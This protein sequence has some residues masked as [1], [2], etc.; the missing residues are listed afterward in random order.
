MDFRAEAKR[1]FFFLRG[2]LRGAT[3]RGVLWTPA[4][5]RLQLSSLRVET[6][7]GNQEFRPHRLAWQQPDQFSVSGLDRAGHISRVLLRFKTHDDAKR[8]AAVLLEL[9]GV[10]EEPL[11]LQAFEIPARMKSRFSVISL[12]WILMIVVLALVTFPRTLVVALLEGWGIGVLFLLAIGSLNL[13]PLIYRTE[14]AWLRRQGDSLFLRTLNGS[15]PLIPLKVEWR[16]SKSFLIK[17]QK[18]RLKLS[19]KSSE[20]ASAAFQLLKER[21]PTMETVPPKLRTLP[22]EHPE[23]S[24]KS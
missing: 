15:V 19:F 1:S 21:C 11:P 22:I 3:S 5:V 4:N 8:A 24:E 14:P 9:G 10:R 13:L 6:S 20:D 16:D 2:S 18:L 23:G 12:F 17:T 7:E